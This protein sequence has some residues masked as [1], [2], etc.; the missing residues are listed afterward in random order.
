[1]AARGRPPL[2]HI[3]CAMGKRQAETAEQ[4]ATASSGQA[5]QC[6]FRSANCVCG[7]YADPLRLGGHTGLATIQAEA[8]AAPSP[9]ETR[10]V[11]IQDL[12]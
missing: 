7:S 3:H 9:N 1:M 11:P 8:L 6:F 12:S 2:G 4:S 10:L 5:E